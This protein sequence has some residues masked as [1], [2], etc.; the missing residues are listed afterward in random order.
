MHMEKYYYLQTLTMYPGKK[1]ISYKQ[2]S[3]RTTSVIRKHKTNN[4]NIME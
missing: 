3:L 2:A 4:V 1:K